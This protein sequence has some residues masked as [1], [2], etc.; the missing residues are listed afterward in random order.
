MK[1]RSVKRVALALVLALGLTGAFAAIA[2]ATGT[3]L[4]DV[5]SSMSPS[6]SPDTSEPPAAPTIVS[7]FLDY[8]PGELVTLTGTG[9]QGDTTVNI[10]VND[11]AGQTLVL[12]RQGRGG[13]GRH[14]PRHVQPADHVHRAVLRHGDGRADQSGRPSGRSRT[15][16]GLLQALRALVGRAA[17]RRLE[18]QHPERQQVQL[19][20]GRGHPPRLHVRGVQQRATRDTGS[21]TRS[22]SRTTGTSRTPTPAASRT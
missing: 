16:R 15:R 22:T 17:A 3:T 6:P 10:T 19:L 11:D 20:R 21:P 9:W 8:A 1:P 14:A 13:L 4:P 7:D 5:L 12:H 2:T 18:Q